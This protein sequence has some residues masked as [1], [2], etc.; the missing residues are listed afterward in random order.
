M[1][2][3]WEDMSVPEL[4]KAL[5]EKHPECRGAFASSADKGTLVAI[6]NGAKTPRTALEEWIKSL[7][8]SEQRA[9]VVAKDAAAATSVASPML[10]PSA[11]PATIVCLAC[12]TDTYSALAAFDADKS[13][14]LGVPVFVCANCGFGHTDDAHAVPCQCGCDSC[15]RSITR[16][17]QAS[18]LHPTSAQLR[19]Y[20][21][22]CGKV[23]D[24]P[25]HPAEGAAGD[26]PPADGAHVVIGV[27]MGDGVSVGA[28]DQQVNTL[29]D[30][31][32]TML[33]AVD[34]GDASQALHELRTL[35]ADQQLAIAQLQ[36]DAASFEQAKPVEIK[37]T[38]KAVEI[39]GVKVPVIVA[40]AR[41]GD[42]PDPALRYV[43]DVDARFNFT[44]WRSHRKAGAVGFSQKAGD[45]IG[46]LLADERILLVGPP[47]SGKTSLFDQFAARCNWPVTR[48]N[49]NRDITILDF[50]GN[51][52]ARGGETMWCDGPLPRAM[53]EG[54]ILILD[55]VDHMPAECSSILHAVLE[56]RGKLVI[57]SNGG[58]VV[59]PHE[60]FRIVATANTAGFGDESG[61]H[62]NAQVQDG[63]FLSRF[64]AVFRV[65]YMAPAHEKK[66][67][68]HVDPRLDKKVVDAIVATAN[69]TRKAVEKGD[70][71]HPITLR[72]TMAWVRNAIDAGIGPAFAM[73]VLNK[74][75]DT[76]AEAVVEIA[77][78][79]LGDILTEKQPK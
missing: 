62:P 4:R 34:K 66:L 74:V 41:D 54:H 70:L 35:A 19:Y 1:S 53:R 51:V 58:E 67:L 7:G 46:R 8:G 32:E 79:H 6:L 31:A 33:T 65:D 25:A 68:A 63:A 28:L 77:Q 52:E 12:H 61:I 49:G 5:R 3:P 15:H 72:Q 69:D 23:F 30:G 13:Q 14:R 55:E 17:D 2:K 21:E 71:V 64:D 24:A 16:I 10:A 40:P 47:A 38:D 76:D 43:P 37:S 42:E 45:V 59:A 78:R 11:N 48:F 57:T 50:V 44:F 29:L 22:E 18:I 36:E 26:N 39:A 20:C 75:S 9:H 56:P 73:S 60:N 27:D